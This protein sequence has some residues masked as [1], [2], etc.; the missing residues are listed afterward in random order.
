MKWLRLVSTRLRV[1]CARA[2]VTYSQHTYMCMCHLPP[3]GG[4]TWMGDCFPHGN[5]TKR[6]LF[7]CYRKPLSQSRGN[8]VR[9]MYLLVGVYN[10]WMPTEACRIPSARSAKTID[11]LFVDCL[12]VQADP[13]EVLTYASGPRSARLVL[14]KRV[15]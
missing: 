12:L 3:V 7:L 5:R 10:T 1:R 13:D 8:V 11:S 6:V 15:A 4:I 2:N 14:T 9:C